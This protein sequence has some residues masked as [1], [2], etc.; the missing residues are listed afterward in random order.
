MLSSLKIGQRLIIGFGIVLLIM[1][2]I[3][4]VAQTRVNAIARSL[5][6]INDVNSAKQRFAINFRGSVHD[7]AINL[8]D[9]TLVSG[10][11][12]LDETIATIKRLEAAYDKS[13]GP[14]DDLMATGRGVTP[15]ETAILA[16]IKDTQ[17]KGLPLIAEV[18]RLQ[19]AGQADAAKALLMQGAR[20]MFRVWLKEINQFIDLEEAKNKDVGSR[21]RAMASG[22]LWLNLAVCGGALIL[23]V[24]VAAWS[25]LAVKPLSALTTVMRKLASGDLSVVIPSLER[26]DEVG[27]MAGAVLIFKKNA[28]DK[29]SDDKDSAD[30]TAAAQVVHKQAEA[31]VL[32][33]ERRAVVG[34]VGEAMSALSSGDLTYRMPDTLA[35][36]YGELRTDFNAAI[37]ALQ[38]TMKVLTGNTA[39]IR[40]GADEIASASEDLSRRTEQQAAS[41]E[42][43]AAALD[44]ITATVRKTAEGSKHARSVVGSAKADAERSGE[45]V[46]NAVAAMGG[47]ERSSLEISQII[48][49]IDEIAFQTN[50]LALNAGVEAARAGDAGRGF[51][52]V[53]S[54]VRALAQR[55]ATAAK[56]IKALIS[57]SGLQVRSGVELVAETGK[58]LSRIMVQV[59]EINDIVINIAASAQ[60]QATALNEVNSAINQMDQVTQQNAAMVEEATAA[61]HGMSQETEELARFIGRFQVGQDAAA[62]KNPARKSQRSAS[63]HVQVMK[64]SGSG[65]AVRKP[66][67]VAAAN[68]DSWEE[69]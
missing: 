41:L 33:K 37:A 11:G 42:E 13:A 46:Q 9:V 68:A 27:E 4:V 7:R 52:V 25:A 62:H 69:F 34:S 6:T 2:G 54:E 45:V 35:G 12:E 64:T 38:E 14:L 29:L 51:A 66:A 48:G 44:E 61:S 5:A 55:S 43:T 67:P 47:I 22:F 10:A 63:A 65:S 31:A 60:E 19:T 21:A 17:A 24:C 32:Q 28:I 26:K 23:G 56:E 8:R 30:R 57:T 53:A 1:A 3:G 36:E 15:D 50:L 49:V 16:S 59:A 18:I 39:A 20:P 58:A 40:S